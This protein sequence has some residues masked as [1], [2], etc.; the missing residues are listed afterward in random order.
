[1]LA[2]ARSSFEQLPN[3]TGSKAIK[4]INAQS[5]SNGKPKAAE[6]NLKEAE[7]KFDS[8]VDAELSG[9]SGDGSNSSKSSRSIDDDDD[10]DYAGEDSTNLQKVNKFL[11]RQGKAFVRNF[12]DYGP[13]YAAK[14]FDVA[15]I[16]ECAR[17]RL[18]HFEVHNL[19]NK[20]LNPN[21]A[22]PDD[23][24]Y[25]P[26][27]WCA[28]NAHLLGIKMLRRA[29]GRI[30]ITTEMGNTPLDLAV[31]MKHPPD[32][33]PLQLKCIEYLLMNGAD[34][35]TRDKGGYGPIDHAAANQDLEV[36][37]LL[38]KHGAKLMRDNRILVAQRSSVLKNVYDPQCYK[39]LYEA[40]LL[41][42]AEFRKTMAK[43]ERT[44]A[45]IAEDKHYEKLHV[46]LSRRKQKKEARLKAKAESQRT[47][48]IAEERAA[49]LRQEMEEGLKARAMQEANIEGQWKKDIGGH[50]EQQIRRPI[51]LTSK[52]IYDRN[53]QIILDLKKSTNIKSY[54]ET[55]KA[56]TGG[57][58]IEVPWTRSLAVDAIDLEPEPDELDAFSKQLLLEAGGSIAGAA[59]TMTG[60]SS[61]QDL[62]QDI[63]YRDENDEELEGEDLEDLLEDLK[64]LH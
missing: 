57:G 10:S 62:S 59:S 36:I 5:K 47:E 13:P 26:M 34:V 54:N 58:R 39:V 21:I 33:R 61:I 51:A 63:D 6:E 25:V 60:A 15:L 56:T 16:N 37:N 29:G 8:M 18:N 45:L 2:R 49:K 46:E 28:R 53:R 11:K 35:N 40:L 19:L 1:M 27:H 64:S 30:N 14:A 38:L 7:Q 52:N 32:R 9:G 12:I 43:R 24:Y 23:L 48:E 20:R 41:E 55:W 50:W 17:P 31:M 42:E 22:D 3:G 44:D 4:P